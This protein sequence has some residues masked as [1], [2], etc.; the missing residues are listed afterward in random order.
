[1]TTNP[2]KKVHQAVARTLRDNAVDTM[3]GVM[4]DANMF[5]CDSFIRDCGGKFISGAHESGCMIMALGYAHV[6]GKA[7][8]CSVTHGAALTNT[9]TAMIEGV[10]ASLPVVLLCGDTDPVDRE[11]IQNVHQRDFV[12]AAGAGYE[13]L[14]S[15]KTVAQDVARAMR[16]AVIER[17]PVAVNLPYDW[18]WADTVY[19]PVSARVPDVRA[20]V[21]A[22]VDIDDAVGIIAGAKRPLILAGRGAG[23]PEARAAIVK[24]AAR[25]DAPLATTVKGKDAFLGEDFDLGIFG[26]V[27][28][29]VAVETILESDCII[30]F[31]ASLNRYTM[32]GDTFAKGK[33]VVQINQEPEEIGKN[34]VPDV[35]VVGEYAAVADLI[36]H[37]L[38]EAEIPPSGFRTEALK[39]KLAG[40]AAERGKVSD[41]GNGT[42][43]FQH[44][45][46]QLDRIFPENRVYVVGG[47]RFM[48][49]SWTRVR[50]TGPESFINSA[51][52]GSIGLGMGY[53]IG[54]AVASGGRPTC[55]IEGDGGFMHAGLAEF[56]TAVRHKLDLIVAICNDGA[57]G[58][59][60]IKFQ[61]RQ[62]NPSNA[63]FDWPDLAPL[64]IA[65]GGE[66]FTVRSAA[67]WAG[68][69]DAIKRRRG[70]LLIDIK[71][72]PDR[73]K[74]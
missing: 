23:S 71:L 35:G 67:D 45:L 57:Y 64:A 40:E 32:S 2:P 65:C 31:G 5:M 62:M 33:R 29:P 43:D 9:I 17:R 12:V 21:N 48:R 59:E 56:N 44:T 11:S 73:V 72:D 19:E 46:E 7:G 26:T 42:V 68:A 30:A 63:R 18:D 4:G 41:N 25:I 14:R 1:M 54:A 8:V 39:K 34:L 74:F 3:F 50:S 47:G 61:D 20:T 49:Q 36:V 60:Y 66:G 16:R 22:S 52:Y 10:K 37:W 24:L 58:A 55:L 27:S 69:E 15:P 28:R 38:D 13:C 51:S 53:A 70:P 6:S